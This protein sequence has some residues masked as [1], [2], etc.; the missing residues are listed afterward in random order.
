MPSDLE[1]R[2]PHE[3]TRWQCR[4]PVA[5]CRHCYLNTPP[6]HLTFTRYL[7]FSLDINGTPPRLACVLNQLLVAATRR[8]HQIAPA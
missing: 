1:S 7:T 8:F 4:L 2:K 6:R 5:M 3:A